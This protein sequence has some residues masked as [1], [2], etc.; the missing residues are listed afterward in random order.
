MSAE[1]G[2]LSSYMLA[3]Q[4]MQMNLIKTNIEMQQQVAE[5]LLDPSRMVSI[6]DTVGTTVDISL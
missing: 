6:S 5:V 2:A 1:L 4:Q 3:M